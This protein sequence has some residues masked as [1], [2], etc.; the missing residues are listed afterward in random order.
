MR[1]W[2]TVPITECGE[3]LISL[4]GFHSRILVSP[5]YFLR[6]IPGAA[7]D[8]LARET[9]AQ[10]LAQ[11]AESLPGGLCLL[12]WDAWR[13]KEV[14]TQLF[15][16]YRAILARENP[17]LDDAA[18]D[19][20]TIPFVSRPS[21]NPSAPSPHNTGGAV[22]LTLADARGVPLPMGTDF[23]EFT[24]RAGT[25]YFDRLS[26]GQPLSEDEHLFVKN[27]RILLDTMQQTGFLNYSGEWW[28]FDYGNQ[29]WARATGQDHAI[30][31]PITP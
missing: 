7:D 30:Y 4:R 17:G 26:A 5:E 28:H 24:D 20:K 10:K 29:W 19:E 23:D 6:G 16:A 12:I 15:I 21:S 9:T 3:R 31:G 14:Q 8:C 18:L 25:A 11:A 2:Q 13:S 22:D 27:R 1:P